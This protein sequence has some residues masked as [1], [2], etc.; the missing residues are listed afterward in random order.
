MSASR[1]RYSL[2]YDAVRRGSL[3]MITRTFVGDVDE[4]DH[5]LERIAQDDGADRI[6]VTP[7]RKD[8]DA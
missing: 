4:L 7:E 5:E 1:R 6:V 3:R 8:V 2:V